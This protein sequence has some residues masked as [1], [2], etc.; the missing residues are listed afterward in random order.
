MMQVEFSSAR[1]A[2]NGVTLHVVDEGAGDAVLLLHG[3]PDSSLLWRHQIPTLVEAGFRVIAPDLRGFGASDR[4][5]GVEQYGLQMIVADALGIL[6]ACGVERA[7]IIGHDWGAAVAWSLA[8]FAPSRVAS[9]AALS[10]AHPATYFGSI[11][12]Y[13]QSWYMLLFQ[14]V[15]IAEQALTRD[16]WRLFRAWTAGAK[17]QEAYIRDLSRPGAL[18]AGLNWYRANLTPAGMFGLADSPWDTAPTVQ[19]PTLG[20]W[21]AGDR[22]CGES[23]FLDPQGRIA[24]P[25]R[26]E[27]I[28]DAGHW[29][30]LDQP[31]RLNRL[32]IEFFTLV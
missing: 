24:G 12:Q 14:F 15:E 20:I 27:R 25:Y 5:E 16:D 22:Y 4:P 28:A 11:A 7:H 19:A 31:E 23:G 9:L 2:V 3:F 13:E 1:I 29:I 6:D 26:Y 10:V 17:D 18:T 21:S 32:L 30:P 8:M